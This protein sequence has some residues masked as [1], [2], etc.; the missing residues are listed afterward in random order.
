MDTEIS[1]RHFLSSS[2]TIAALLFSPM[3]VV[4][5]LMR[6]VTAAATG[7]IE[8]QVLP[9]KI[10][11]GLLIDLTPELVP[12]DRLTVVWGDTI[13][14]IGRLQTKGHHLVLI[15]RT[16]RFQKG[17]LVDTMAASPTH[18]YPA[19]NRAKDGEQPGSDGQKGESG[20]HG[21][22]AG[23]VFI[24]ANHVDGPI[25]ILADGQRGGNAQSGG[26]GQTGR[27]G[28]DATDECTNGGPGLSG[29]RG[30]LAGTPG[31]GGNGGSIIIFCTQPESLVI[32]SI[33][34]N[35]GAGGASGT[36]GSS[37]KGGEGGA[38]GKAKYRHTH[39]RMMY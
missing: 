23:D 18:D 17:A 5:L 2:C 11:E 26:N 13:Q 22:N 27:H 29:G 39:N 25:A 21:E 33:S 7:Q 31:N 34:A 9:P 19:G 38:P 10:I 20:D 36:H 32:Q 37:A 8:K 30:G 24:Y 35:P 1:R 6:D 16:I 12:Q 15:A 28:A 14:L 4:N 3:P